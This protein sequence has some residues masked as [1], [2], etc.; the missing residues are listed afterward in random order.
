MYPIQQTRR[1]NRPSRTAAC[2]ARCRKLVAQIAQVKAAL[3]RESHQAMRTRKHL[4]ELAL[5]EAEA[6]AWQTEYPHLVFPTLAAEKARAVA[7]WHQRQERVQH[8]ISPVIMA[9]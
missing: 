3:L 2:L 4:L 6:M 9:A 1:P 5:N 7:L 8:T